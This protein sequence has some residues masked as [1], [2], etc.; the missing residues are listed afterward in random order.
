MSAAA[1]VR[2][3][4]FRA[5]CLGSALSSVATSLLQAVILWQVYA[6]SG[7]VLSLG[8]VGLVAFFATAVSSLVGGAVVDSYDRRG[9]LFAAQ[10]G[11]GIA[12]L[13]MLAAI[14]TQHVSLALI[15][16][17]VFLSGVAAS[18]EGP[19]RQAILPEII[20]RPL[21]VD[22]LT[23][24]AAVSS[25]TSVLGPVLT[26]FVIAAA[27]IGAA[28]GVHLVLVALAMAALLTLRFSAEPPAGRLSLRLIQEGVDFV[29]TRPVLLGAM[30][31][32]MFAVLFGG[33][34]AL[35]PVYAVD[36]LHVD[37][38]G[39]GILAASLDAGT[40]AMAAALIALPR[41]RR[42][43]RLLL[44]AVAGFGIATIIFG[45]SRWLPLSIAAYALVGMADQVSMVTRRSIIQLS[46]PDTLRGRVSGVTSIFISASNELGALESGLVAA[47]A[48]AVFAV[49]SGGLACL[50]V[51]ALIGWRIP[52]LRRYATGVSDTDA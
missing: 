19:A 29:R 43:G 32:D 51:V 15:Y 23:F 42:T 34:G 2:V 33:A 12:S 20:P 8:V 25:A 1:L 3:G 10:V 26:G 24:N 52:D 5:Y 17:L 45:L 7:S 49:V 41:A 48:G 47:A 31:L 14:A 28:Y 22:A 21:Y 38:L 6:I 16:G 18:L 37:A 13:I 50:L 9:V 44:L 35:L 27:G 40:L 39:Y 46:T 4:S 30:T 11:P 36:I